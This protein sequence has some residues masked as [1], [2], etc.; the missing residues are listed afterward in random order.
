[1]NFVFAGRK[2]WYGF[3]HKSKKEEVT[4]FKAKSYERGT[5]SPRCKESVC[6]SWFLLGWWSSFEGIMF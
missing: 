5:C 2:S 4:Y 3:T 6:Q 1:M